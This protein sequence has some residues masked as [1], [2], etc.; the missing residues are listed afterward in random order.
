MKVVGKAGALTPHEPA[1]SAVMQVHRVALH[2]CRGLLQVT[3]GLV[4]VIAQPKLDGCHLLLCS[5]G[6]SQLSLEPCAF[7]AALHLAY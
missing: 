4:Q 3:P 6:P 1:H 2:R 5:F 7:V